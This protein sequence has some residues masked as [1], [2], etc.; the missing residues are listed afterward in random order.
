MTFLPIV[1]RELRVVARRRGTYW[2]RFGLVAGAALIWLLLFAT[3]Q[4]S[5]ADLGKTLFISISIIALAFC[6]LAGVFLTADC[7]SEEKRE[8]TLGLLFLTEL[9]GYDVVFGKLIA[10]SVHAFYGLLATLPLLS[11]SLLVGG[12]TVGEFWRVTLVLIVTLL[13]SLSIGMAVSG[14]CRDTRQAMAWTLLT[15]ILLAGL[16]P[17]LFWF[18]AWILRG[19]AWEWLFWFSPPY[20][21]SRAFDAYFSWRTGNVQFWHSFETICLLSGL[22]LVL[23]SVAL[24]RFWQERG[25]SGP[26]HA[27]IGLWRRLRFGSTAARQNR[28]ARLDENPFYWLAA[29]DRAVR[30]IAVGILGGLLPI[31]SAFFAAC[32]FSGGI[33]RNMRITILSFYVIMFMAYGFHLV[34]KWLVAMESS[35][36]LSEDRRSGALELLLVTPLTTEQILAGQRRA[37]WESFRGPMGLAL[38]SNVGLFTL[39]VWPDFL[40]LH[41]NAVAIFCEMALGGGVMMLVD[42]YALGWIG[43]W[44]A[45][46]TRKHHRAILG[47]MGRVVFLPWLAILFLVFLTIGSRVNDDT[48]VMLLI[49]AW[50]FFGAMVAFAFG[51]R[52]KMALR[53][54]LSARRTDSGIL[55]L[56]P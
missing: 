3:F 30:W 50:F 44:R 8:G 12:V 5:S 19:P 26:A 41:G 2:A 42:F 27:R 56:S 9:K 16:L 14:F 15:M 37:L 45:L 46:Q 47:T 33:R 20:L 49:A 43:M 38:I 48:T 7:L 6:M 23:A 22:A 34:V 55:S 54:A 11:L 18:K 52:A 10:T 53:E 39:I 1:D 21:Y 4:G 40:G 13:L 29:R 36:R 25:A 32:A 17:V 28:R 24:P 31:W 35:R 51:Q